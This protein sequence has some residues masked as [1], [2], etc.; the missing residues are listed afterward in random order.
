MQQ[1]LCKMALPV[2]LATA[3][4][5]TSSSLSNANI[6]EARPRVIAQRVETAGWSHKDTS[7]ASSLYALK[8]GR[9]HKFY[10]PAAYSADDWNMWMRKMSK[11]AKLEAVQEQLLSEYLA[12]SRK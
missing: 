8:C 6:P 4:C 5:A 3:G 7:R 12:A 9:C 11:K 1:F 2:V 10:D